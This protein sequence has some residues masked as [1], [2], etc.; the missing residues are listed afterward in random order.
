MGCGHCASCETCPI[1]TGGK[2]AT[3]HKYDMEYMP[4]PLPCEPAK[5]RDHWFHVHLLLCRLPV[6]KDLNA[7]EKKEQKSFK[8]G[9]CNIQFEK[10]LPFEK[11][12][13]AEGLGQ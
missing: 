10:S 8:F 4:V 3:E 7:C 1:D 12:L 13:Q 11:Q 2:S 5:D 9:F 6:N